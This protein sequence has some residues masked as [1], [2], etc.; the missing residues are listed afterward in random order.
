MK[1]LDLYCGAGGAAMGY[2][3]AGFDVVG[4]DIKEQSNYPFEFIQSDVFSLEQEFIEGFDII[5]ASP[6]CQA[7]SYS[8]ARLR[9][10]GRE[11]P[12]LLGA[13]RDILTKT[14]KEYI[15]ENVVGAK[16]VK[17]L[18][19]CGT[20]FNLEVIRHR[21]FEINSDK[22]VYPPCG[23][24][25]CGSIKNG[26]YASVLSGGNEDLLASWK[27]KNNDRVGFIALREEY[28]NG[29]K[30]RLARQRSK[31]HCVSGHGGDSISFKYLDWC[32]A[33]GIDWMTKYEL[34]QAIP[35]AYCEHIGKLLLNG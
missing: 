27:L 28:K 14:D 22:W 9:K 29:S 24:K 18:K 21:L 5:H 8:T 32:D 20:M 16:L 31:Y 6:P 26:D 13:T 25:H 11:Y 15:I 12:D 23:C 3:R 1:L 35:P 33:M 7:Y 34:T 19:L 17:P 30:K 2:H 10:A 4:V